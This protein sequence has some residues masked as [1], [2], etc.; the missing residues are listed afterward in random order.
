MT[1]RMNTLA[2]A[3]FTAV[4]MM[5]TAVMLFQA[6]PVT[7]A[8]KKAKTSKKVVVKEVDYDI[9]DREVTFDFKNRVSWKKK[10]KVTIKD[11]NGKNYVRYII[12]K[13]NDDI[14]V[15]VKKLKV[16]KKYTYSISGVAKK[17]SKSYKKVK[18]TFTAR[19]R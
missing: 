7:A 8:T 18:G 17:G 13:D 15:K 10:P 2:A 6:A 5:M 3:I 1:K 19:D 4:C 12:E 9:S 11:S 14:E 16:G